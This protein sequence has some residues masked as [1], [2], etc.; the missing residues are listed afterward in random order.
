MDIIPVISGVPASATFIE[1]QAPVILSPASSA[2]HSTGY[3]NSDLVV[4]LV[5]NGSSTDILS[6]APTSTIT[7]SGS[8]VLYSGTDIGSYSGGTDL[9]PLVVTFNSSATNASV[10][11]VMDAIA[12][13]NNSSSPSALSR[14]VQFQ[15]TDSAGDSSSPLSTVVSMVDDVPTI[16]A[17]STNL[18]LVTGT[19]SHVGSLEWFDPQ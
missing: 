9:N 14:T 10:G 11:K 17:T 4:S 8:N 6:I 18:N 1:G 15:L 5:N 16:G 19:A 3:A 13:S 7:L 12:F 2:T